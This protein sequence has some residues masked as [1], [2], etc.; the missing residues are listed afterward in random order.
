MT[1]YQLVIVHEGEHEWADE[2]ERR[3]RAAC[4]R[5]LRHD[6]ALTRLNAVA[7]A[8]ATGASTTVVCIA[9]REACASAAVTAELEAAR[10]AAVPVLPL[11]REYDE[12]EEVIPAVIRRLSAIRWNGEPEPE[13]AVLRLLGIVESDRRLFLSYRRVE[14]SALAIQLRR[15]LSERTYDVFL[16]RFSVP[17]GD[18][19]QQ[20]INIELA[21]KAFLLVLESESAIGSEWVQHEVIYALSHHIGVLALTIP[22]TSTD[23]QFEVIDDA[24][25]VRLDADDL[26]EPAAQ[27]GQLKA[28]SL[29]RVLGEIELRYAREARRRRVQLL[30]AAGDF[31]RQAGYDRQSL[32]EWSVLASRET[33][34]L[35]VAVTPIAPAP[36]A[37]RRAD[38][39]RLR[40]EKE[41]GA[42]SVRAAYLVH[43]A[44]DVDPDGQALVEWIVAD[45]PLLMSAVAELPG[46]LG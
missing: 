21:D 8:V 6:G 25:R 19:F 5:V 11:A 33:D 10:E 35:V 16:D 4:V 39:L 43:E 14:T 7:D 28:E 46:L 20:R 41:H 13:L 42:G 37:L 31:L 12:I 27:V 44:P 15:A 22:G 36:K 30:A 40:V 32:D 24:F 23:Q 38:L 1:F 26:E 2:V 45:R 3:I 18:D 34:R 17:P 29:D 9:T